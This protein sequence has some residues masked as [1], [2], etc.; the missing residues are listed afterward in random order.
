ML[1][2]KHGPGMVQL[3]S[4]EWATIQCSFDTAKE[5]EQARSKAVLPPRPTPTGPAAER[6]I[7]RAFYCVAT[8]DP[9]LK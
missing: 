7:D 4:P 2:P 8:D 9:R 6:L 1:L 5:C 3:S